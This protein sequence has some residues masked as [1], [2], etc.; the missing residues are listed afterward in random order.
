MEQSSAFEHYERGRALKQNHM[1]KE[2]IEEFRQAAA[3][4]RYAGKS[5]VQMAL[6]LRSS[7]RNEAAVE[8]FR[9]ALES[10]TFSSQEKAHILYLQ[11]QALESLGRYAEALEAYGWT[12]NED[13]HFQDVT[14]R[15]KHLIS[16]ERGPALRGRPASKSLVGDP[17]KLRLQRTPYALHLLAQ[18]WKSFSGY[19]D[20]LWTVRWGRIPTHTFRDAGHQSRYRESAPTRPSVAASRD[21]GKDKRQHVRVAV[22]LHGHFSSKS[23]MVDGEGML[24]DLSPGGCRVRSTVAVPVGTDLEC[25]IFPQ[26]AVNPFTI[27]GATVCWIRPQEFGLA[28]TKVRPNVQRHIAQLCRSRAPLG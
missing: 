19:A 18:A 23:R 16:G 9:R 5:Y 12:R 26:D 14:Q 15:I 25:C 24:R 1:F 4:P 3:E 20:R 27:D 10:A 21:R 22:R 6:C 13:P 17:L 2:A 8:A 28:F 7:E 11:A